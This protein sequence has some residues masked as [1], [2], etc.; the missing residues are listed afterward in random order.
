VPARYQA[1]AKQPVW[2]DEPRYF[3][4]HGGVALGPP[5]TRGR[6]DLALYSSFTLRGGKRVLWYPDRKFFLLG[7]VLGAEWFQPRPQESREARD[8]GARASP[9]P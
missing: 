6:L 1:H 2:F 8:N 5:K 3:M 9:L 4:D 7:R